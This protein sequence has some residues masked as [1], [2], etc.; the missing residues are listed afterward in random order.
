VFESNKEIFQ[1]PILLV[2]YILSEV[3]LKW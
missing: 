2:M 1:S 3:V